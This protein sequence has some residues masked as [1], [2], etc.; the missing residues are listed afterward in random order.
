[1]SIRQT[2][3][4]WV[5]MNVHVDSKCKYMYVTNHLIII[6]HNHHYDNIQS[7]VLLLLCTKTILCVITLCVHVQQGQEIGRVGIYVIKSN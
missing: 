2:S 7:H 3:L 4:W 5:Y 1:M 6:T